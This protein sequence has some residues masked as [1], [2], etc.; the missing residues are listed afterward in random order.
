AERHDSIHFTAG[1]HPHEAKSFPPEAAAGIRRAG[2]LPRA[3]AIGEIGLDY[4][5][6]FSPRDAQRR[7]FL[8]QI[9]I[10]RD[11]KRPIVIHT[12]EAWE[13]TLAI[14]RQEK[15]ADIGGVFH[16]FSGGTEEARR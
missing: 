16:C 4:H 7:V 14:L 5:Y 3:V 15:A 10:A 12:R 2:A 9:G 8:E 6:D 13:H 1:V 11:L